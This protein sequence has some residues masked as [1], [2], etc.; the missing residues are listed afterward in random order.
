MSV[1]ELTPLLQ[2]PSTNYGMQ[3]PINAPIV[4]PQQRQRI[5][6]QGLNALA[7]VAQNSDHNSQGVSASLKALNKPLSRQIPH[8]PSR[9]SPQGIA[10]NLLAGPRRGAL[11]ILAES[12][13]ASIVQQQ[14]PIASAYLGELHTRL[15]AIL[16]L[17]ES[18]KAR[19]Q[20][21]DTTY[22]KKDKISQ[23]YFEALLQAASDEIKSLH[24]TRPLSVREKTQ[25]KF[26]CFILLTLLALLILGVVV[27]TGGIAAIPASAAIIILIDSTCSLT[28]FSGLAIG[29]WFYGRHVHPDGNLLL[30]WRKTN[31]QESL[32]AMFP[33]NRY[34]NYQ[35]LYNALP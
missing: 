10:Q 17:T 31:A 18:G 6:Q 22:P 5:S 19:L 35:T 20:T 16:T 29:K 7:I 9:S 33:N 1:T 8:L 32:L 4:A 21:L 26:T 23:K 14:P 12:W 2:V 13:V 25:A 15:R 28:T 24:L 11:D 30:R 3:P 27:A 34:P